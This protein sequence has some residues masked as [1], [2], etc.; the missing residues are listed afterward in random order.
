MGVVSSAFYSE[1]CHSSDTSE[2]TVSTEAVCSLTVYLEGLLLVYLI[3]KPTL[4]TNTRSLDT[5]LFHLLICVSGSLY[6]CTTEDVI[7]DAKG[8][9]TYTHTH[10]HTYICSSASCIHG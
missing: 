5:L 4:C 7:H 8:E 6:I 2:C 10:I 3:K 9:H 1:S